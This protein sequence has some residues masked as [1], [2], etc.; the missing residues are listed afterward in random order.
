VARHTS[1]STEHRRSPRLLRRSEGGRIGLV[2]LALGLIQ[3]PLFYDHFAV[4]LTLLF[5][6]GL[7]LWLRSWKAAI[8]AVAAFAVAYLLAVGTG[9]LHDARPLWEPLLGGLLALLGGAVGGGI[10]DVLRRDVEAQAPA[11]ARVDSMGRRT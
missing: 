5:G 2:A 10:F 4:A 8:P 9:W 3:A 1:S 6:L 11:P 7:G